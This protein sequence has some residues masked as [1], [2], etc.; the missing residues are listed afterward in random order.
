MR[1]EKQHE[2]GSGRT[3]RKKSRRV[4]ATQERNRTEQTRVQETRDEQMGESNITEGP[5]NSNSNT[6]LAQRIRLALPSTA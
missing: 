4:N 2:E 5:R 3:A 1:G 6:T